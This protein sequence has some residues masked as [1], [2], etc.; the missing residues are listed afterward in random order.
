MTVSPSLR[1]LVV[2]A[3]SLALLLGLASPA[4]QAETLVDGRQFGLHVPQ[5][6]AGVVPPVS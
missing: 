5:I 6:A 1:S 4:A 3:A 2:G